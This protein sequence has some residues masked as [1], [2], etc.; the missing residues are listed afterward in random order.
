M[1][2]WT[3][4]GPI[5]AAGLA[6]CLLL[7]AARAEPP[8]PCPPLVRVAFH[9]K[10]QPGKLEGS[11]SQFAEP[12]GRYVLWVREVLRRLGC[13]R[14]ELLRVPQKRL[15]QDT[16]QG[17]ADFTFFLAHTPE[18]A[19]LLAF[20]EQPPG[21]P[22]PRLSLQTTP[23]MLFGRV[24]AQRAL[25]W[26]G[27]QLRPEGARVGVV[28]GG[29]EEPLAERLGWPL[30]RAPNHQASV[31]KLLRGQVEAALLTGITVDQLGPERHE[32]QPLGPPLGHVSFY[33]P[34]NKDFQVRHPAFVAAFWRGV[35][36]QARTNR[37]P[38]GR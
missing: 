10:P 18:R 38:A 6:G 13:P 17:E 3:L 29:V 5:R 12:P 34:A 16:V 11:G 4:A 19:A 1:A 7:G 20:P 8:P 37:P 9:D 31:A 21:T 35:A 36:E 26:D 25:R 33:A 32:L 2:R 30:E 23:L 22:D 15:V 27:R 24:Q 28:A 14:V